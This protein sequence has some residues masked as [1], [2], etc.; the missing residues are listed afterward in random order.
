ME[1]VEFLKLFPGHER[2]W[3]N[4][5]IV[6]RR[7]S[8]NTFYYRVLR[9]TRTEENFLVHVKDE[10]WKLDLDMKRLLEVSPVPQS[11]KS[12]TRHDTISHKH[13]SL[14]DYDRTG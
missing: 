11:R 8:R 13:P 5:G 14:D 6:M 3:E 12:T 7:S 2:Q 1:K 10:L 4:L 9:V